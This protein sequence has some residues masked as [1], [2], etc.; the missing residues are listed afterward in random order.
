MDAANRAYS[1][2][3]GHAAATE[4]MSLGGTAAQIDYRS[5]NSLDFA[6]VIHRVVSAPCDAVV[7]VGSPGDAATV[8]QQLRRVAPRVVIALS[9]WG[10]NVQFLKVAG[11]AAEDTIALQAVDLDSPLPRMREFVAHYRARFGEAPATPA[12]QSYEAVMLGVQAFNRRGSASLRTTLSVPGDWAGLDGD[13]SLDAHG[14]ARRDVHM[15]QVR[16][17]RFV[18]LR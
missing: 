11:P 12:V 3:F 2:S 18:P 13:F 7:L 10:A 14:D 9:P 4:F 16:Q 5:G 8:A 6:G 15:T 17:G 1:A